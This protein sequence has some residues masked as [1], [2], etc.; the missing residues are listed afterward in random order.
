MLDGAF[1]SSRHP[2][3]PRRHIQLQSI[4]STKIPC[5]LDCC[6]DYI[7]DSSCVNKRNF[8]VYL[9]KLWLAVAAPPLITVAAGDLKV[10]VDTTC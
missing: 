10:A 5:M 8:K 6:L 4:V 7:H 3:K 9:R 2:W 1:A